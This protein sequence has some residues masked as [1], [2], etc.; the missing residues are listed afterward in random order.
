MNE[1]VGIA[2]YMN[3][4][5][6]G[7]ILQ[8]YSLMTFIKN[9]GYDVYVLNFLDMNCRH[10]K[11]MRVKLYKN[12]FLFGIKNPKILLSEIERRKK[13]KKEKK[14][15]SSQKISVFK[16]FQE[17]YLR[18]SKLNYTENKTFSAFICG[19]DQIW[20]LTTLGLHYFFFL[21]FAVPEKRI[22]Y[23][24]SF[25]SDFL[26]D[27]N[28]KQFKKYVSSF[29]AISVR[30]KSGVNI[31]K[32]E[33]G[34][35]VPQVLDPVFLLGRE[36]WCKLLNNSA[37]S[38]NEAIL[39]NDQYVLCYFLN[40]NAK[41]LEIVSKIEN[42]LKIKKIWIES[43]VAAF[44]N[45]Q[46]CCPTPFEFVNLIKNAAYV[47][48]DSFHGVAFSCM[49]NTNFYVVKRNYTSSPEQN[50][51]IQSILEMLHLQSR[52]IENPADIEFEK[53]DFIKVNSI[54]EVEREKSSDFLS[55]ALK[56]TIKHE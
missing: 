19:S 31:I 25:G 40:E 22:A 34:I 51:R 12:K 55:T 37:R 3:N 2:T 9:L 30:E 21:Q 20:K 48:T 26:P 28:K 10:N 13:I 8:A 24:P 18:F 54:L 36:Y 47:V 4:Y 14:F 7:S 41:G 1:K 42:A 29:A 56:D 23:A 52:I 6:Y 27:Y 32:K 38:M 17:K 46:E 49:M 45:A 16:N 39:K 15:I 53:I 11:K 33:L 35:E 44:K 43:G 50:T 5:N